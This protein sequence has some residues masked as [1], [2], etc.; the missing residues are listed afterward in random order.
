MRFASTVLKALARGAVD[1]VLAKEP[2][3]LR[4]EG[5]ELY[6]YPADLL[7]RGKMA[8]VAHV[9]AA[10]TRTLLE[11]YAFTVWDPAAQAI[12]TDLQKLWQDAFHEGAV[13]DLSRAADALRSIAHRLE[14][15]T[16]PFD[17]WM[18][19]DRSLRRLERAL[20]DEPSLLTDEDRPLPGAAATDGSAR[21]SAGRPRAV[22]SNR[23]SQA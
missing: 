7:L 12:Q 8:L 4:G 11:G 1:A 22:A 3:M 5:I 23:L 19:L 6:L 13:R 16:V 21:D 9:R 20:V 10:M 14:T 17:Q 18:T 15:E 2:K